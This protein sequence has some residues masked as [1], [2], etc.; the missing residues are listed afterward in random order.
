MNAAPAPP[1]SSADAEESLLAGIGEALDSLPPRP[2]SLIDRVRFAV[3]RRFE[4]HDKAR[5]EALIRVYL[6]EERLAAIGDPDTRASFT[7]ETRTRPSGTLSALI[8]LTG[9]KTGISS[10]YGCSARRLSVAR[11]V[12]D[13]YS[14]IFGAVGKSRRIAR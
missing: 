8:M 14:P 5:A 10:G 13:T 6:N 4:T 1:V 12:V 7:I 9:T 11:Y 2:P 3:G